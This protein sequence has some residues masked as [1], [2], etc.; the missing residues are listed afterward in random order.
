M[1]KLMSDKNINTAS[2]IGHFLLIF[3]SICLVTMML[4]MFTN[5]YH[6]FAPFAV[7]HMIEVTFI[8]LRA[9]VLA[10]YYLIELIVFLI[11]EN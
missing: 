9:I 4:A 8:T 3:L 10:I 6:I 5:N 11:K 1:S 2:T 7:G